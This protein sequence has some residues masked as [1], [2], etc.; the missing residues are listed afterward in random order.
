[1]NATEERT[2]TPTRTC[3][4]QSRFGHCGLPGGHDGFHAVPIG[5]GVWFGYEPDRWGESVG[6]GKFVE[7]RW[8]ALS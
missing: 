7:G 8:E 6:Y 1:M 4:S 2:S 3:R 5:D